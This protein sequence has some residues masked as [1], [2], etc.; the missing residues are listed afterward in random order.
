MILEIS[1]SGFSE[2][3]SAGGERYFSELSNF[4]LDRNLAISWSSVPTKRVNRLMSIGQH[5]EL[6]ASIDGFL[7]NTNPVPTLKTIVNIRD[8]LNKFGN[9]IDIIHIHNFRTLAGITWYNFLKQARY[10]QK[11][12]FILTDHGSIFSPF[13]KTLL[14]LYD[15][16]APVSDTS[17]T[18][19]QSIR[20]KPFRIIRSF[21]TDRVFNS[22]IETPFESRD[23]DILYVGRLAPWKGVDKIIAIT[24]GLKD[25]GFN[26]ISVKLVGR[27]IGG[28][29]LRDLHSLISEKNLKKNVE[30]VSGASD[31]DIVRYYN[32]SKIF[33]HMSTLSDMYGKKYKFPELSSF[34]V[35]EALSFGNALIGSKSIPAL[36]EAYLGGGSVLGVD[37][38]YIDVVIE[39]T[40]SILGNRKVWN[41][42]S[43]SNRKYIGNNRLLT[44][45]GKQF[46]EFTQDILDG[47]I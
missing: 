3:T 38:N 37:S 22:Y 21:V 33:M 24:K 25:Q 17:N 14:K 46:I 23:I 5:G 45:V 44:I 12:K 10:K 42:M 29:Y 40:A 39:K 19:L 30:I 7:E 35:I 20:K 13:P 27:P 2:S 4:L 32:S 47:A 26:D 18:Y 1:A 28:N 16:Y 36:N 8:F 43:I 6:H 31:F 15:Y 34:S 11:F 41:N 9:E